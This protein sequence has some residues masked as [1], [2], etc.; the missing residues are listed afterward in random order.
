MHIISV[1]FFQFPPMVNYSMEGRTYQYFHGEP[2]YPFGYG[3]SYSNF[4]YIT[5][6]VPPVI[7]FGQMVDVAVS[8][9]NMGPFK[10]EEVF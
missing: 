8:L 4:Q 7:K 1:F 3:L 10:A 6:F 9:K 5:M 2:L